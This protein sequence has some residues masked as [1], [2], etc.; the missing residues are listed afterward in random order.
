MC[1]AT[2][3]AIFSQSSGTDVMILK[4]FSPKNLSKNWRF[5][6]KTKLNFEKKIDHHIGF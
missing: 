5:L 2:H 1:L 4:I 6:L 3:W